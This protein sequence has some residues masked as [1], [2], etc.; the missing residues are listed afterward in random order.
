MCKRCKTADDARPTNLSLGADILGLLLRR[1]L[2]LEL[3]HELHAHLQRQ[4]QTRRGHD[5]SCV[6][7]VAAGKDVCV[8]HCGDGQVDSPVNRIATGSL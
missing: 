5:E 8:D 4:Q 7:H 3:P 2:A 6:N 1:P